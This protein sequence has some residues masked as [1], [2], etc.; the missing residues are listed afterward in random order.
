LK[1]AESGNGRNDVFH[2]ALAHNID[3]GAKRGIDAVLK[4][5][6]LD[7]LVLPATG[8][9]TRPSGKQSVRA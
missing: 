2:T 3:A 8:M 4:E 6:S 5:Y 7:A 9:T 1:E